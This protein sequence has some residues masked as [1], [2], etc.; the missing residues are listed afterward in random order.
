[1]NQSHSALSAFFVAMA[2]HP[3]VQRKA[4]AELDAVVGE[5]HFPKLAD[6]DRLPYVNAVVK[7][8][9]RWHVVTPLSVPHL[10]I[11][12]DVYDGYFIPKDSIVLVNAW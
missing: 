7:E 2:L 9:L 4:Q 5:A 1:M 6:R 3:D 8:L 10:N 11:S 12:D